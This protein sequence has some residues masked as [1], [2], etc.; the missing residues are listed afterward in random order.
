M[1]LLFTVWFFFLIYFGGS[2]GKASA[3]N[4]GGPG[5]IPGLG[6]SPGEGNGNPLQY[7][8]LENPTDGGACY[9]PRGCKKSDTTELH[10]TSLI[11]FYLCCCCCVCFFFKLKLVRTSYIIIV[12]ASVPQRTSLVVPLPQNTWAVSPSCVYS[13]GM[14]GPAR[15]SQRL[16]VSSRQG[17]PAWE[18]WMTAQCQSSWDMLVPFSPEGWSPGSPR[19]LSSFGKLRYSSRDETSGFPLDCCFIEPN[20]PFLTFAC[21]KKAHLGIF[22]YLHFMPHKISKNKMWGHINLWIT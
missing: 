13:Q 10:F 20:A 9:S 11:Y 16:A 15:S 5:S 22:N 1:Y 17:T 4:V 19:A 6:R 7:S 12:R 14:A 18:G 2:D 21:E 3:C 8:C